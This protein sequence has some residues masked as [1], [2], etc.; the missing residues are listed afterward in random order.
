MPSDA[1]RKQRLK[2][3]IV[4]NNATGTKQPSEPSAALQVDDQNGGFLTSRLTTVERD[5]IEAPADGLLIWNTSD[6]ELQVWTDDTWVSLGNGNGDGGEGSPGSG[7]DLTVEAE[8]TSN[9]TAFVGTI[10]PVGNGET[11]VTVTCPDMTD[12]VPGDRFAVVDVAGTANSSPIV[13]DFA[14]QSTLF[15]GDIAPDVI[16]VNWQYV[17][18]VYINETVGWTRK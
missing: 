17:E 16:N 12:V 6:L 8:T 4:G 11:D 13:V 5:A 15:R 14:A 9:T 7:V 2:P 18:Y 10:L 3:I 1:N